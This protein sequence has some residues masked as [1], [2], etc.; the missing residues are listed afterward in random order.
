MKLSTVSFSA[1]AC[2]AVFVL[3]AAAV[4]DKPK[5]PKAKAPAAEQAMPEVKPGPEHAALAKEV[6]TW[7]ATVTNTMG[8]APEV[9][10]AT[11]V[12]KMVGGLWLVGDFSG[13]MGG[14]AFYGHGV[15][16]YDQDKKKYVG[17]WVDTM[18]SSMMLTEGSY[19]EATKTM[20]CTGKFSMG[21]QEM[22]CSMTTQSK[23][24]D[25]QVFTMTMPGEGGAVMTALKIEYKRRK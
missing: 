1:A 12:R 23:D 24:A 19:D 2:V 14:K 11:E 17:T 3:T 6:G 13:E 10:K 9:S 16:G 22:T 25:N 4:Q 7:D 5:D 21:G 8:G 18:S 15:N 20:H